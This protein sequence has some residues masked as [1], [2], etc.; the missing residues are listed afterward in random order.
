MVLNTPGIVAIRR[1][2][3]EEEVL[4][5][6]C[7]CSPSGDIV[8]ALTQL[9]EFVDKYPNEDIQVVGDFNAKSLIYG[10]NAN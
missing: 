8:T 7:Y 3:S 6:P 5:V 10:G 9:A 2:V 1:T 4:T